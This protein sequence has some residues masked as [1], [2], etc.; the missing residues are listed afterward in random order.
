MSPIDTKFHLP[1]V[2]VTVHG[3]TGGTIEDVTQSGNLIIDWHGQKLEFSPEDQAIS[4]QPDIDWEAWLDNRP[5]GQACSG[6][7]L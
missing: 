3:S 4:L 6:E 7:R 2:M 5:E 1:G